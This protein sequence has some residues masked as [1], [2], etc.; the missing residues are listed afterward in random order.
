MSRRISFREG[1]TV[2]VHRVLQN[3]H[4]KGVFSERVFAVCVQ[5]VLHDFLPGGSASREGF[6]ALV[7][8]NFLLSASTSREGFTLLVNKLGQNSPLR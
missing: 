7:L 6:N 1:S 3:F 5:W 8:Q 2:F 4:L